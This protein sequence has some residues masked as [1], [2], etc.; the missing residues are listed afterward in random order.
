MQ[1]VMSSAATMETAT[2]VEAA[3]RTRPSTGGKAPYIATMIK[4]TERSRAR[5]GLK[6]RSRRSVKLLTSATRPVS[7]ERV[8]VVEVAVIEVVVTEIVAVDNR[9][10]VGDVGV[11]VVDHPMAMPVA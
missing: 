8:A 10:A 1:S 11:V 7:G 2:S 5:S 6:V 4:A 3:S 9:P